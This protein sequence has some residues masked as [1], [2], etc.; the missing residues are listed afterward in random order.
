MLIHAGEAYEKIGLEESLDRLDFIVRNFQPH[1]IGHALCLVD[2]ANHLSTAEQK[3]V[4]RIQEGIC[5]EL[6][7]RK[8][9][10]ESCPSSN[11]L[12]ASFPTQAC[13]AARGFLDKGLDVVIGSDDPG[14]LET[15]LEGEYKLLESSAC[16]S[17]GDLRR[18]E[19]NS[20][21]YRAAAFFASS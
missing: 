19:E 12:L 20:R 1:R 3:K 17:K 2:P 8:I 11:R 10:V 18:L 5:A 13:P 9:P 4:R 7:S 6:I 14:L 16:F 15:S 21:R